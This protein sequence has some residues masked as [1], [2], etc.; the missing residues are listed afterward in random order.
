MGG[1]YHEMFLR[2][3]SFLARSIKKKDKTSG[4]GDLK[5]REITPKLY[6]WP[7]LPPTKLENGTQKYGAATGKR[8]DNQ[9][10]SHDEQAVSRPTDLINSLMQVSQEPYEIIRHATHL[11]T[12]HMPA[13]LH[14]CPQT[15][16]RTLNAAALHRSVSTM[17][18]TNIVPQ[19]QSQLAMIL[20]QLQQPDMQ[21][22][23]SAFPM[24]M[25]R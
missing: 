22:D 3:K 9:L 2:G 16:Q 10:L 4:E 11:Q 8:E 19:T 15:Q 21:R 18:H 5:T 17:E 25:L 12:Q 24:F 1:Y 23:T 20:Q 14:A 13:L 6:L 7:V